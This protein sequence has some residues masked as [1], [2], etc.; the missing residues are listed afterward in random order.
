MAKA[1]G[2][3]SIRMEG[4]DALDKVL[5]DLPGKV[6][7][8]VIKSA[9]IKSAS[10]ILKDARNRLKAMLAKQHGLTSRSFKKQYGGTKTLM[11]S[12]LTRNARKVVKYASGQMIIVVGPGKAAHHAWWFEHGTGPRQR[13]GGGSTGKMPAQP[14]MRPAWDAGVGSARRRF[15]KAAWTGI[16]REARKAA[17][18]SGMRRAA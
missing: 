2:V 7:R 18:K 8:R 16:E 11:Q 3:M 15:L 12:M 13:S 9:L 10:P 5:R 17:A 14:F 4:A 1:M 6:E